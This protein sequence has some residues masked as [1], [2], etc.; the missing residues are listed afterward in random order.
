MNTLFVFYKLVPNCYWTYN[1]FPNGWEWI[2]IGRTTPIGSK[3]KEEYTHEEQFS[4][5]QENNDEMIIFLEKTF[6]Q[7]K[8]EK[9]IEFFKIQEKYD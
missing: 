5:P 4:G 2:G 9:S 1:K 6:E 8:E 3:I 7:L